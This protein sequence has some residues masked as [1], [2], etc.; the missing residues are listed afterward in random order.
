[1]EYVETTVERGM[2]ARTS[3]FHLVDL[4]G[5]ERAKRTNAEGARFKEG[6]NINKGLLCLGNVINALSERSS[7]VPY[8]D[9]KLTRL[10][11]DSL[12]GNSK[13]LMIACISPADVNF[14]ETCNTLRY[15]SRARNIQN[16]AIINQTQS[17]ENQVLFLK[18]QLE[19]MQLQLLQA[20][21][22]GTATTRPPST[23]EFQ[24][25]EKEIERWRMIAKTRE[26]ELQLVM[27]AKEKWKSIA[28]EL[29]QK[30]NSTGVKGVTSKS[31]VDK[32]CVSPKS[33]ALMQE[34]IDFDQ[35]VQLSKFP[36]TPGKEEPSDGSPGEWADDIDG[37][38]NVIKEKERIV[39]ALV[40]ASAAP[41]GDSDGPLTA[42]ALSYEQKIR[43]LEAEVEKL[44]DERDKS[45]HE[46]KQ[47]GKGV[48]TE[49]SQKS[50]QA[51]LKDL[52]SQLNVA[53][54]AEK[55]C[56]RLTRLWKSGALKIS[57]LEKEIGDMK[58]QRATLQKK[59][60]EESE[61]HRK[62]KR[63]QDLK[64][65]QL[66][67][68][69]QRKQYEL[70]KL[71]ALHAKQNSVLKRK[72]EEIAAANKRMRTLVEQRQSAQ[73]QRAVSKQK[74]NVV[75]RLTSTGQD[76]K[77]DGVVD[78]DEVAAATKLLADSI[79]VQMTLA[80][81]RNAIQLELN[82]RKQVALEIS[83]LEQSGDSAN[84][85]LKEL[86]EVL[87]Q[88][89]ADIRQLQQKLASV[90]KNN[91]IPAGLFSTKASVCHHLIRQ[92][93]ESVIEAKT[94]AMELESCKSDLQA[95]E[96]EL[97]DLRHQQHGSTVD[98][99]SCVGGSSESA[100]KEEIRNLRAELAQV[101]SAN[102]KSL[103]PAKKAKKTGSK[104]VSLE[105]VDLDELMSSSDEEEDGQDDDSD[106][107]EDEDIADEESKKRSKKSDGA[108][109]RQPLKPKTNNENGQT[110]LNEID[111]L[112]GKP[113]TVAGSICC[114]CNG[115][116]AT[117]SCACRAEKQSCGPECSCKESKCLNRG[118]A[119]SKPATKRKRRSDPLQDD[120]ENEVESFF[121]NDTR[122]TLAKSSL[123]SSKQ[124]GASGQVFK[125][126]W[127][128]GTSNGVPTKTSTPSLFPVATS[129]AS[130]NQRSN[131]AIARFF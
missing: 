55:E 30:R 91:A 9:S 43:K 18:Q 42:L 124:S 68:Q 119:Q 54:H 73:Q 120:K 21:T 46:S 14:E 118:E 44:N 59:L 77:N 122:D 40:D 90:E 113:S 123:D 19:V 61:A 88:K 47:A 37:F 92:L 102:A 66:K 52:Q 101:R 86:K 3:K 126:L 10:L 49:G 67:R 65:L 104:R 53:R 72:N 26:E 114:S 89:N 4:A 24:I 128:A 111:E 83:R 96:E 79:E 20:K 108:K 27:S 39:K 6:V 85:K 93:M 16:Q 121:V 8:R 74:L 38:E 110:I 32:L 57:S 75:S 71:S 11:Q 106:Y 2:E 129:S 22:T 36:P 115:K 45:A 25:M 35:S 60:K 82:D 87:Q 105:K 64:I 94:T 69:D 70:Q 125:R 107:V 130:V 58:K 78:A 81:A 116:C 117:K 76:K 7:H 109:K 48:A 1:M 99:S 50:L 31:L 80:G 62:Q 28:D 131:A 112:L 5:S 13:T 95:A 127:T 103:Q 33:K 97:I 84:E 98:M 23:A 63:D 41:G 17:A 56:K 51:K 34:A 100:L 29:M 15:A 12:G